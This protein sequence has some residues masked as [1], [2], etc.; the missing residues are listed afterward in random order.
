MKKFLKTFVSVILA[1]IMLIPQ[2]IIF[3]DTQN[4]FA[5]SGTTM[6]LGS[7]LSLD[8]AIDIRKLTG[9]DNYAVM[10]IEYADGKPS[11][12]ITIPQS[13]WKQYSG[14]IYTARFQG[15]AAKQMNDVVTVIFYNSKGQQLTIEKSDSI[16]S[17]A[18]RMLNDSAASNE[19]LRSV[20]VDMLNYGAAAQ[21][22]F[23]YDTSNLANRNLTAEQ[24]EWATKD[25]YTIN[26]RISDDGYVGSTLTV[27]L[28]FAS[29]LETT[30]LL[31]PNTT[32]FMLSHHILTTMVNTKKP[33]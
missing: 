20:Y 25:V 26:K 18:I 12:T 24:K 9:T 8:F 21:I 23:G 4:L 22:Q 29:I 10:T 1:L 28:P 7:N 16:E 3:A 6:T 31:V 32:I 11:D 15:M 33:E 19:K 27:A 30:P 17:Y 13:E 2:C 5:I 14:K